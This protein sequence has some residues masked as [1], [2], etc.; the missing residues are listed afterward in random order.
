MCRWYIV[1]F[2]HLADVYDVVFWFLL[3]YLLR[4]Y[5]NCMI[6]KQ[7]NIS[8]KQFLSNLRVTF[9]DVY[10]L[11]LLFTVEKNQLLDTSGCVKYYS[12]SSNSRLKC[13]EQTQSIR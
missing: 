10:T 3:T 7:M 8:I 11:Y 6:I 4:L 2:S 1:I 13:H 9:K 5:Y 12:E